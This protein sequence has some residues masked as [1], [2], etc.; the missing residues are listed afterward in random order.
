MVLAR[1]L[2]AK[3]MDSQQVISEP[4]LIRMWWRLGGYSAE[5]AKARI[6]QDV[7]LSLARKARGNIRAPVNP[8]EVDNTAL[9][10]LMDDQVIREVGHPQRVGFAHD[11]FL[12][13]T[14]F[15]LCAS[16]GT[17]W[18]APIIDAG[19]HPALSR[20]VELLSQDTFEQGGSWATTLG[21]LEKQ[22]VSSQWTRSWLLGPFGSP[23][24]TSNAALLAET[25]LDEGGERL[26]RLLVS[27]RSV[28]TIA[29]PL[30]IRGVVAPASLS[31][32]ERMRLADALSWPRDVDA[33]RDKRSSFNTSFGNGNFIYP[34]PTN[35]SRG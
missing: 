2:A 26:I 17:D 18:L 7:L 20:V 8:G 32:L 11:I 16:R 28:K 13:W 19:E 27:M 25:L 9:Q 21:T 34:R 12:E 10:D 5:A 23:M 35:L 24:V 1:S 6:R 4:Q 15:Q 3:E 30:V 22:N 14:F 33:E 31:R 29:N